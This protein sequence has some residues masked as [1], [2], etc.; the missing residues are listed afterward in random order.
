MAVKTKEGVSFK[1]STKKTRKSQVQ[2][3]SDTG[4]AVM[5]AKVLSE[6]DRK[7]QEVVLHAKTHQDLINAVYVVAERI[8]MSPS[9]L[10]RAAKWGHF[11]DDRR[12]KYDGPILDDINTLTEVQREALRDVLGLG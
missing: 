9:Q 5:G 2:S 11:T 6:T 4:A 7:H 12:K 8:G 1:S 10:L 3:L